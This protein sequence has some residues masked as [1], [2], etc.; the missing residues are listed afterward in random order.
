MFPLSHQAKGLLFGFGVIAL[1][2]L[3][4]LSLLP[5]CVALPPVV[6][7]AGGWYTHDRIDKLEVGR[8]EALERKMDELGVRD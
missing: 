1:L 6:G 7:A 2:V 8:I 4:I 3:G 5:G